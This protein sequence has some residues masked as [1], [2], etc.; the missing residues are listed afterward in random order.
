MA[1]Q[2]HKALEL[3]DTLQQY[4]YMANGDDLFG[5]YAE[6]LRRLHAEVEAL[7][8]DRDE[9]LASLCGCLS[10]L[11]CHEGADRGPMNP[12]PQCMVDARATI[13]KE[14]A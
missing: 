14:R 5:L 2:Q 11:E 12:E 13:T 9:V 1:E 7:R 6:E 4:S 8:K 3:A 10:L